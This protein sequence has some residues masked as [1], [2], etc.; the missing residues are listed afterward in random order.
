MLEYQSDASSFDTTNTNTQPKINLK[1]SA[2]GNIFADWSQLARPDNVRDCIIHYK[3]LNTNES[4]TIR[5]SRKK[6]NSYL[7]KIQP[8]HLYEVH[9]CAVDSS[10]RIIAS[11]QRAQIQT[12]NSNEGPRLR[13][14]K[15][16]PDFIWLEWN[17]PEEVLVTDIKSYKVVVNGQTKV[18]LPPEENRYVFNDGQV[19][20]KYIFQIEMIRKDQKISSSVPVAVKWPG[21]TIPKTHAN[22]NGCEELMICWG[23]SMS[24]N[25][26]N[27]EF[28]TLHLY[29]SDG[30]LLNTIGPNSSEC[31]QICI[32]DMNKGVY[33]YI[34]EIKLANSNKSISS[35]PIQVE[36]GSESRLPILTYNYSDSNDE[37]QLVNMAY[38]L[39]SIRDNMKSKQLI[40]RCENQLHQILSTLTQH[41]DFI[42]IN[43]TIE[44]KVTGNILQTYRLMIDDEETNTP[45]PGTVKQF[46]L[47][48]PRRDKPYELSVSVTPA[49]Y[50]TQ[51]KKVLVEASGQLTFFCAHF[52][53][54]KVLKS[55]AYTETLPREKQFKQAIHQGFLKTPLALE[56]IVLYDIRTEKSVELPSLGKSR[57]LTIL[58][59]YHNKCIPSIAHLNYFAKYASTHP[60]QCTYTSTNCVPTDYDALKELVKDFNDI[61]CYTDFSSDDFE[62][63]T[64][65]NDKPLNEILSLA[66]VP[67]YFVLDFSSRIVW[68][69]RICAQTQ[70]E[71]DAHMDHIIAEVNK[72]KC[73]SEKCELCQ[74][75][76]L[77]DDDILEHL[78]E[79]EIKQNIIQ[80]RFLRSQTKRHDGEK[81]DRRR[82]VVS[83]KD[84]PNKTNPTEYH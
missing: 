25:D 22:V 12:I 64:K 11:S 55:C 4:H 49:L 19:A 71:Y 37:K 36:C 31:R 9:V 3:S 20:K 2:H 69:G 7:K 53:R 73:S 29:N 6:Q 41:T 83:M 66:G 79:F 46:P 74:Y 78:K 54:N 34:L 23:D 33:F 57:R 77:K 67:I 40:D 21:V 42:R 65:E 58:L 72:I 63:I 39:I 10:D 1:L 47:Q 82:R 17:K 44:S 8:G 62:Y 81:E 56:N 61:Q 28:Y 59:F 60:K 70:L 52:G 84:P 30:Q 45:I 16:T 48:L 32:K 51:S 18:V 26:G 43:I 80:Q 35:Q 27:I 15:A 14:T 38:H 76:L 24:I 5:V 50:G 13:V 68:K 75:C